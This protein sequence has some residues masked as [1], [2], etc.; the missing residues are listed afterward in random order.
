MMFPLDLPP[1]SRP[2]EVRITTDASR[3]VRQ[4]LPMVNTERIPA[5]AMFVGDGPLA[6]LDADTTAYLLEEADRRG[7]S[8]EQVYSEEEAARRELRRITPP[9]TELLKL[10]DRY[11]APQEWYDE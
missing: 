1:P 7:V 3:H 9:N 8:V 4:K 6:F 2:S 5:A 11:P 10:A